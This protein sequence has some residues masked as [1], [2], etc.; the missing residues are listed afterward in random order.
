MI[1]FWSQFLMQL[2]FMCYN[3]TKF[4]YFNLGYLPNRIINI[5]FLPFR[6]NDYILFVPVYHAT[7]SHVLATYQFHYSKLRCSSNLIPNIKWLSLGFSDCILFDPVYHA[8]TSHVLA[9]Y[10]ISVFY[11]KVYD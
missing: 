5:K 11:L 10:Q 2:C 6:F 7:M 4:H 9:L 3:H 8:T 1:Y